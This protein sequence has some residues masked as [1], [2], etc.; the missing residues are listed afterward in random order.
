M[1]TNDFDTDVDFSNTGGVTSITDFLAEEDLPSGIIEGKEEL[2]FST[3]KA[4]T[5]K[6]IEE[7][8][9]DVTAPITV[10]APGSVDTPKVPVVDLDVAA[11]PEE[12]IQAEPSALDDI[13][14][15]DDTPKTGLDYKKITTQ[16]MERGILDK[17]GG[18]ETDEGEVAFEDMDI[19]EE[20]FVQLIANKQAE[21]K[22]KVLEGKVSVDGTSEFTQ[23]LI[24]I[25]KNGGDVQQ[26]LTSYQN[27][28]NPLTQ[29]DLSIVEDQHKAVVLKLKA[30]NLEDDNI[31]RILQSYISDGSLE[32][33]ATKAKEQLDGAFNAQLEQI[34]QN[35]LA[36]KE[37]RTQRLKEYRT[38]LKE[39][40][41]KFDIND[42]L[43]RKLLD[44][45]TKEG[46][47]GFELDT[48]YS[49][50]R[51]D[52]STAADLV[53][54]L[55]NK[56]EFVKQVT[57]DAVRGTKLNTMKTVKIIKRRGSEDTIALGDSKSKKKDDDFISF[58]QF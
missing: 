35:A 25:E 4:A 34:N 19:D 17:I 10:E 23:K 36:E 32:V 40:L 5:V 16:L 20:T 3:E 43:K 27:Y 31:S 44:S 39:T 41:G 29:L 50:A 6:P 8:I 9:E 48:L 56:E 11:I 30:Q 57:S 28:K 15:T 52:P 49:E 42:S 55:T 47:E 58:D 18:F 22:E 37:D 51:K 21:D 7:V 53:L 45:A 1:K 38:G 13:T 33:E 2:S 54:F 14:I 12:V 24:E 26:A 46:Q